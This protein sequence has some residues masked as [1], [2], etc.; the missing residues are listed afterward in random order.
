MPYQHLRDLPESVREHLP[1][2]AQ[3]IYRAAYNSAWDEYDHDEERAHRVAWAAV[4]HTYE[5]NEETGDWE[6]KAEQ[7]RGR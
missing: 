6:A 5:K 2:H 4:K 3:E 7:E 1:R